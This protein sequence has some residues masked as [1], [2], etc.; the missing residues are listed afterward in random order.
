MGTKDS[1][2]H[3]PGNK[4]TIHETN[5][6]L[7]KREKR[8]ILGIKV[9]IVILEKSPKEF[10]LCFLKLQDRAFI[11]ELAIQTY[12]FFERMYSSNVHL[13]CK[14]HELWSQNL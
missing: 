5:T 10:G 4:F 2:C 12:T 7:R 8:K 13:N 3:I 14:Y 11:T 1:Q 6:P 9:H